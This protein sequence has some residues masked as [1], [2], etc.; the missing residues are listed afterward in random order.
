MFPCAAIGLPCAA[1]GASATSL[2]SMLFTRDVSGA[3]VVSPGKTATVGST[4][5]TGEEGGGLGRWKWFVDV[6]LS[7]NA[8]EPAI[9][10]I[11]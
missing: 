8:L 3:R 4:T 9:K 1:S 11:S 7:I 5:L 10:K 2:G 6:P